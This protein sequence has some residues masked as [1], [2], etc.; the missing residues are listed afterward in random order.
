MKQVMIFINNMLYNPNQ[1][2]FNVYFENIKMV[3]GSGYE[4]QIRGR[5]CP[6]NVYA[7]G[8][9]AATAEEPQIDKYRF[10]CY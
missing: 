9:L 7:W 4:Q 5:F 6:W 8:R 1:R 3:A 10:N 2:Y